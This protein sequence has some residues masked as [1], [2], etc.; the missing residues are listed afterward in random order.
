MFAEYVGLEQDVAS[1]IE[2]WRENPSETKS[3]ILRRILP[4]R[5][6]VEEAAPPVTC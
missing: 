4:E 5:P 6:E 2:A 3:N 1:Q